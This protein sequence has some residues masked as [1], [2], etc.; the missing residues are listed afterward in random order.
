[1]IKTWLLKKNS[2]F[3]STK[4]QQNKSQDHQNSCIN[5]MCPY[6]EIK[7]YSTWIVKCCITEHT[8]KNQMVYTCNK[9]NTNW[10]FSKSHNTADLC[11]Q[12]DDC[13]DET[14]QYLLYSKMTPKGQKV[15]IRMSEANVCLS[16]D[17]K[18][19][20][21]HYAPKHWTSATS[22]QVGWMVIIKTM[23]YFHM[24]ARYLSFLKTLSGFFD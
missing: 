8:S 10:P 24:F 23:C 17:K 12:Q 20:N 3:T 1:M 14:L 16:Q 5:E 19:S 6:L 21:K 15:H 9:N 22:V 18:K 11:L 2:T 7:M 13:Y 4:S